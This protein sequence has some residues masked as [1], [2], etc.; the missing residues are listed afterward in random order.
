[1]WYRKLEAE[2]VNTIHHFTGGKRKHLAKYVCQ[3]R[4]LCSYVS[5]ACHKQYL[6]RP[7]GHSAMQ[8]EH[9]LTVR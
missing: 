9:Q 5:A 7:L 3:T 1:M 6:Q 4:A 8:F 2:T